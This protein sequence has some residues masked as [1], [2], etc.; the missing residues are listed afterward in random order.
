MT[1]DEGYSEYRS[2]MQ[3]IGNE[4]E[5]FV[6]YQLAQHGIVFT[7]FK[8]RKFQ[9]NVGENIC[10]LEIKLDRKIGDTGNVYIETHEKSSPD[11][12]AYVL[13][14]INR[15]CW[16][17]IIG[18]EEK[19]WVFG[20]KWLRANQKNYPVV[21]NKYKTSRGFLIPIGEADDVCLFYWDG[22]KES[23]SK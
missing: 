23:D 2:K 22:D 4:F 21:T 16:L 13:S 10:G 20:T 9:Y 18:D 8:S 19:F 15:N 17:Y 3:E 5:D 1:T 7:N 6:A 11:R 12:Q 14:G